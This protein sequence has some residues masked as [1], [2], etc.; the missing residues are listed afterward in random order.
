M[1]ARRWR[2]DLGYDGTD[3]SGW[4]VQPGRRTVQ[5]LLADEIGRVLR[6]PYPPEL[7]CAGRT[8]AGV[9]ARGQVAHLDLSPDLLSDGPELAR[10]LGR[11]LPADVVVRSVVPAPAGFDARFAAVWRRYVYRIADAHL[12][13][14]LLRR[15]VTAVRRPLDLGVLNAAATGLLGLRDFAAFC[16][17]RD[18]AT[19][20][21]TL[22]H[23]E[24]VRAADG[25]YVGLVEITV[26]ADAFCHSMV[27]SLVGALVAVADGHRPVDW[28]RTVAGAA[29][30]VSTV[31]VMAPGGLTLE[32]VGYPGPD[33]LAARVR[34]ARAV[35]TLP[36]PVE[37]P[38]DPVEGRTP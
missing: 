30:R 21:R 2:I 4:A 27:R 5:G 13:D 12:P 3:F 11:V 7:V 17:R 15:S 18:G 1:T 28:L 26:V 31:E 25:P 10:R 14:P 38:P 19:T 8:D 16:R 20:V 34:E 35:R 22:L 29:G 6:L 37:G 23:C 24:A 32:E 9:H 36:E 33:A